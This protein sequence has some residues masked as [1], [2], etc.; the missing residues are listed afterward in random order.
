MSFIQVAPSI[1][2]ANFARL[3]EQVRAFSLLKLSR[4]GKLLILVFILTYRSRLLT[5]L[6]VTGSMSMLWTVASSQTL[7][8]VHWL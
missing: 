4:N 3:G 5:R 7:P 1:L 6:D 2:S 8:S